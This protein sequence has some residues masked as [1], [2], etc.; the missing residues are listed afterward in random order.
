M[1]IVEYQ[2]RFS[3]HC[4]NFR[5]PF[6]DR[7]QRTLFRLGRAQAFLSEARPAAARPHR[8][9]QSARKLAVVVPVVERKPR[10]Y[11][12]GHQGF[13]APLRQQRCLAGA[14]GGLQGDDRLFG[15]FG[16]PAAE[17]SALQH[18]FWN[19]RRGG[20]QYQ[21]W[22]GRSERHRAL[23]P[24][25]LPT[26]PTISAIRELRVQYTKIMSGH[27]APKTRDRPPTKG[28]K[29]RPGISKLHLGVWS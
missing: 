1:H 27:P 29:Q 6:G 22:I 4:G 15:E 18:G 3:R 13:L 23:P 25:Y 21:L 24:L 17:A 19:S 8:D 10:H 26:K 20:F 16:Q 2:Q 28:G 11:G 14:G 12:S 5:Q 9:G 7:L